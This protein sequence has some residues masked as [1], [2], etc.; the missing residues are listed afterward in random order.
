MKELELLEKINDLDPALLEDRT[1]ARSRRVGKILRV[2]AIAAVLALVLAGTVYALTRP[3]HVELNRVDTPEGAGLEAQVELPLVP[4]DSFRGEIRNAG[5]TIARQYAEP[6]PQDWTSSYYADPGVCERSFGSIEE[7]MA[8]M[9]LAKLKAPTFP[10]ENTPCTVT[11]KGDETGA[12]SSVTLSLAHIAP[13]GICA[14]ET[15]TI[16]TDAATDPQL[17]SRGFWTYEFP[18]DVELLRYVTPGGNECSIAV[19]HPEFETDYMSLTGYVA[20]GSALYELNLS[21]VPV[22]EEDQALEILHAWA[23]ALD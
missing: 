10:Y 18:R 5:E 14:Q 13:T 3:R 23:D 4:W 22:T 21:A 20:V 6:E 1:P 12:V 9:G 2:A 8:Y 11:A 16:L 15:A 7:A 17:V 19:L